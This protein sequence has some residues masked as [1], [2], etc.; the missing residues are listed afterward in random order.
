[1]MIIGFAIFAIGV[2][3]IATSKNFLVI[4][5]SIELVIIAASLIGLALYSSYNGDII[6]LL[7]SIWSIAAVELVAAIALYRY[8]VKSGNGL[9]VSKL[10]KYKG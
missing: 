7:I 8:L 10:S 2:S 3:G 9:D 5:F 4:M 1:M 6:L